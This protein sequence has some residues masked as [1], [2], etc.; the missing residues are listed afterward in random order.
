M[1]KLLLCWRYLI[2]RYLALACIIS[3]ML[4]VATLIVVNSVMAGFSTKLKDRLHGLLSDVLV[5]SLLPEGFDNPEAKMQYIWNSPIG[6][7][8][9]AMTPTIE[10]LGLIQITYKGEQM[11]PR[12]VKIIGIDPKGRARIGGF[13]EHLLDPRNRQNPSFELSPD[14]KRRH[15]AKYWTPTPMIQPLRPELPGEPPPPTPMPEEPKVLANVIVGYA[16]ANYRARH[17]SPENPNKDI[18]VLERGDEV[19]L[20]TINGVMQKLKPVNDVVVVADIFK[21]DMSEYDGQYVFVPLDW[22]QR[23]RSMENQATSLQIRLKNYRDAPEVVAEL[24]RMFPERAYYVE[25]WEGKQGTILAAISTERGLLNVLLFLIIGVAGFGILAIFAMIVAEKKRDIG[26]LKALGAS[27]GGVLR[28]FVG[29]ALLLGLV[30]AALGT[31]LGLGLTVYLNEIEQFV[32]RLTGQE[33]FP[34]D[35]Y[36]FDRIPTNIQPWMVALVNLGAVAIA[37]LFSVLPALRAAL[38]HPVQALRYE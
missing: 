17:V 26:I 12:A 23:L 38:L 30:G 19:V 3:I 8:I 16:I 31:M 29:Y 32:G 15:D 11:P 35:I 22:L 14:V 6:S 25:T 33:M 1:Y 37:V 20:V 5:E 18:P 21:S 13:A 4:G 24:S 9:E 27:N 28:I 2:S 7:K 34:R 10:I 36:Y